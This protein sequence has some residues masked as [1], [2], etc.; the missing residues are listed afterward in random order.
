VDVEVSGRNMRLTPAL[1]S[2]AEE[3]L[4]RLERHFTRAQR[5]EVHFEEE[6][7]RRIQDKDVCE[8]LVEGGGRHLRVRAAASDPFAAVD[9]AVAK[10]EHQLRQTKGTTRASSRRRHSLNGNRPAPDGDEA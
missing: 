6:R 7:N 4:G 5:A 1:R 8:V 9:A 2:A 3:K 10:L